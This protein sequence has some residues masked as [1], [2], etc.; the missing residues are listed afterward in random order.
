MQD[1]GSIPGLGRSPG[2]RHGNL[3]QY[4]CLENSHGHRSLAGY[5]LW[6]CKESDT[7]E[8]LSTAQ[9]CNRV[10]CSLPGSSVHRILQARTGVSCHA[11]LQRIFPTQGQNECFLQCVA[12]GFFTREPPGKSTLNLLLELKKSLKRIRMIPS[13]LNMFQNK[14]QYS[15]K[16]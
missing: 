14:V 11:L 15:L 6:G 5:N 3:F 12:G 1:P 4:S 13:N 2:G 7:I 16:D 9:L 8:R 10:D